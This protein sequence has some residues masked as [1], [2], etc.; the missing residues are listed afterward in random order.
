MASFMSITVGIDAS[1]SRSGGG[2]AHMIG[3]LGAENELRLNQIAHVHLWAYDELLDQIPDSELITK[4]RPKL[5]LK[6]LFFELLWQRF[7]FPKLASKLQCD[8]VLNTDASTVAR[9][10]PS[11]T[12]SRDALSYEPGEIN[13]YGI[14]F[15]RIR[16]IIIRWLQNSSL[17]KAQGSV[18]LSNYIARLIQ[19]HTGPLNR[20]EVIP[21]GVGKEFRSLQLRD[22]PSED[23]IIKILY[24]SNIA[25]YKH[26]WKIVES[27]CELVKEGYNLKLSLVGSSDGGRAQ[28]LLDD[29]I[30]RDDP[31]GLIV[32]HISE[33]LNK[34]LPL[35]MQDY[36]LF[37]FASSCET[38]SNTL[39][40]GIAAGFPIACSNRGPLPEILG[41]GGVYFDPENVSTI[42]TALKSI[43]DDSSTRSNLKKNVGKVS[44]KY[45][46]DICARSTWA[47]VSE[48]TRT[49]YGK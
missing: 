25:V 6:N 15:S 3:L 24:V 31:K 9:F 46:W 14:S 29:A 5:L 43:L 27:V 47:F 13:R 30:S 49:Y 16:L 48:I 4:H 20:Y 17:R 19:K 2:K 28:K 39:L 11:I 12:M 1:R 10:N 42:T 34:D 37:V 38:I 22:W 23:E 45:S 26:Q 18:F 36:D 32:E 41:D 40:E 35:L 8:I 7:T 21:H 44:K 33:I